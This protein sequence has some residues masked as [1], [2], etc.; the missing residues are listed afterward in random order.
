MTTNYENVNFAQPLATWAGHLPGKVAVWAEGRGITYREL[1]GRANRVADAAGRMG[2]RK[3][4]V[5]AILL[6]TQPE[7][8]EIVYGLAKVGIVTVFLNYRLVADEIVYIME[9]SGS[10]LLFFGEEF[11]DTIKEVREKLVLPVEGYVVIGGK[12]PSGYR[13]YED[14]L[15]GVTGDEP[16]FNATAQDLMRLM[17]TSGTTGFPKGARR[18]HGTDMWVMAHGAAL[19]GYA[20]D[21]V[22][23]VGG[24]MYH[25]GPSGFAFMQLTVGGSIVM[26]KEVNPEEYLQLVEKYRV[27]HIWLPP[28]ILNMIVSLPEEVKKRYDVSSVKRVITSGSALPTEVRRRT[29]QTFA[30]AEHHDFYGSTEFGV[31]LTID[32]ADGQRKEACVGLPGFGTSARVCRPDGAEVPRGEV[33]ELWIRHPGVCEGYH[34]KPEATAERFRDGWVSCDDLARQDEEGYYYIVDRKSD[35]I[36]SGGSNIYPAEVENVLY[37]HPKVLEAAVFGV[38]D[39]VWQETVKACIV[40]KPGTKATEDEIKEFCRGKIA[41]YKVPKIV[42]FVAEMPK[43]ASGK[44]LKR[45]LKAME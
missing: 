11:L 24:A 41:N 5:V 9:D 32:D 15:T 16:G 23:I 37:K 8:V 17:Y 34:N 30:G 39:P 12:V 13:S 2:L 38:P 22:H 18:T 45:E 28:V 43:T 19:Y 1:N 26:Q 7:Y 10:K 27:T 40:L 44:I 20:K 42:A 33:G 4:D 31:G 21:T 14:M 29:G 35:M 25:M 36:V 6:K 3:G